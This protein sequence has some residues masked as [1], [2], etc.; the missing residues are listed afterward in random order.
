MRHQDGA[1]IEHL[2]LA[3]DFW[4]N[5][6]FVHH[7]LISNL[8]LVVKPSLPENS[9]R[10]GDQRSE[11]NLRVVHEAASDHV[12]LVANSSGLHGVLKQ[13]DAGVFQAAGSEH[14]NSGPNPQ[15]S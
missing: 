5:V 4:A 11:F 14:K 7:G 10:G 3:H 13:Q 6:Q 15:I 9:V 2:L 12:M 8:V 1:K